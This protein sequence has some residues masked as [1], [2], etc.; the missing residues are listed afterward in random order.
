MKWL[1]TIRRDILSKMFVD[2]SKYVATALVIGQF[3]LNRERFSFSIFFF[4]MFFSFL[5]A[6]FALMIAPEKG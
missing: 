5:F 2:Y 1:N 4:G 3:V 6:I